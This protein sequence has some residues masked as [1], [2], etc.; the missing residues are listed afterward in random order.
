MDSQNFEFLRPQYAELADLRLLWSCTRRPIHPV[1][2]S[3][4]ARLRSCSPAR[5]TRNSTFTI[6]DSGTHHDRNA[7]IYLATYPAL[8][9]FFA[10]F[11]PGFF[12]VIIAD[13]S[14]RSVYNYYPALFR[15]F[16]C[17]QI[18]LTA[19]PVQFISRNSYQLVDCGNQDPT[20]NYALDDAVAQHYLVAGAERTA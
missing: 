10:N 16:D 4:F 15:Y 5:S 17:L 3:N 1:P 12:D 20:F 19:T 11:D 18:G 14:H 2:A 9:G 7:H 8:D 13:E 6:L